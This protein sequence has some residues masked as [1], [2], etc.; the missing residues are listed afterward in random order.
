MNCTLRCTGVALGRQLLSTE[1]ITKPSTAEH[2]QSIWTLWFLRPCSPLPSLFSP[3]S[4]PPLLSLFPPF[5][6]IPIILFSSC[7]FLFLLILF[8]FFYGY[9]VCEALMIPS[10]S[11]RSSAAKRFLG[12]FQPKSA[13]SLNRN[14][15]NDF[16]VTV[17]FVRLSLATHVHVRYMSSPVR[18]SV[19]SS[20]CL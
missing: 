14:L 18:L 20:V 17:T 1:I 12:H 16:T 7:L 11:G 8:S 15:S 4:L 6:A 19:M 9:S 2:F 10:W 5:F 3:F 13:Y